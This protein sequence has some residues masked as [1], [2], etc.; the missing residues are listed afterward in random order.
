MSPIFVKGCVI[1]KLFCCV[2]GPCETGEPGPIL[3]WYLCLFAQNWK[4]RTSTEGTKVP[5]GHPPLPLSTPASCW[6]R[7]AEA[8]IPIGS[9]YCE[10]RKRLAILLVFEFA[11]KCAVS[12]YG[13]ELLQDSGFKLIK[14][15]KLLEVDNDLVHFSLAAACWRCV[16]PRFRLRK[17]YRSLAQVLGSH[18]SKDD[19]YRPA[20]LGAV[21]TRRVTHICQGHVLHHVLLSLCLFVLKSAHYL[22]KRMAPCK[23]GVETSCGEVHLR[24]AS[25][26]VML[27]W[28]GST[29]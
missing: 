28:D 20:K 12:S 17:P 16:Y 24:K 23:A 1:A 22:Q 25:C 18:L 4:C 9:L 14:S 10:W 5:P 29:V 27:I 3:A 15:I 13:R 11:T 8:L 19:W 6:E 21:W 26:A 2:Q 7:G